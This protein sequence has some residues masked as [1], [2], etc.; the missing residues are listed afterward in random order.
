[1]MTNPYFPPETLDSIIDLLNDEPETLKRCCLV[2]KSWVPRTRKH[3]FAHIEFRSP[4]D[5]GSWKK[6]FPDVANS[7][8]YY[9]RTLIVGYARLVTAS[10]GEEGGWIRLIRAFSGV[11]CLVVKGGFKHGGGIRASEGSLTPFRGISLTLK[12]LRL[13]PILLPYPGLFDFILSFPLLEDLGLTGFDDPQFNGNRPPDEPQTAIPS[14]SPP[15]TGTL[16]FHLLGG[17]V[18]RWT[19]RG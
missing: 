5:L 15:F 19:F 12:S 14:T 7:P 9:A 4:S 1:M 8:G 10:D 17:G 16:G 2:S 13:G 11:T 3:L 18:T 6:A